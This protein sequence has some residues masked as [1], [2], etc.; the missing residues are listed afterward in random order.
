MHFTKPIG[1]ETVDIIPESN[2][3]RLPKGGYVCKILAV[4]QKESRNGNPFLELS[5]DIAEGEY[6]GFFA[7]D[8]NKQSGERKWRFT[9]RLMIPTDGCKPFTTQLFKTFNTYVEDSNP[10]WR[11]DWDADEKQYRGKMIG[12]LVNEKEY[13]KRNGGVGTITNIARIVKTS[14]IRNGS[15]TIPNDIRLENNSNNDSDFVAVSDAVNDD[16]L[17]F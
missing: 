8:Y 1:Y 4:E 12:V 17:P 6:V 11:F 14:T 10:G 13:R 16:D 15:Y 7:D 2:Y 3:M 9:H 5:L